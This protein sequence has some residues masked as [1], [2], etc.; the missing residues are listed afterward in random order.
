[1]ASENFPPGRQLADSGGG[2]AHAAPEVTARQI[3][4]ARVSGFL[5]MLAKD[6]EVPETLGWVKQTFPHSGKR[7]PFRPSGSQKEERAPGHHG[8][9]RA[10]LLL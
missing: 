7:R 8:P 9:K 1:M 3:A 2:W 4:R 10:L 6:L 5:L